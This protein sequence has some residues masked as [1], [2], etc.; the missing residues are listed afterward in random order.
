MGIRANFKFDLKMTCII[1]D[2]KIIA[3]II[4]WYNRAIAVSDPVNFVNPESGINAIAIKVVFLNEQSEKNKKIIRKTLK[5][6]SSIWGF[7]IPTEPNIKAPM[8]RNIRLLLPYL[9]L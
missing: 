7:N 2:K 9:C 1:V 3:I 4:D 6:I 8:R 5:N